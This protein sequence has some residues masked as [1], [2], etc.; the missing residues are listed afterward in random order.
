[1][2]VADGLVKFHSWSTTEGC[3]LMRDVLHKWIFRFNWSHLRQ[4]RGDIYR[5]CDKDGDHKHCLNTALTLRQRGRVF[6]WKKVL[7]NLMGACECLENIKSMFF[8]NTHE[9][10]MYTGS[11]EFALSRKCINPLS[12][13]NPVENSWSLPLELWSQHITSLSSL[14]LSNV[15]NKNEWITHVIFTFVWTLERVNDRWMNSIDFCTWRPFPR[16]RCFNV[17]KK[18]SSHQSTGSE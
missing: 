2:G 13:K 12:V 6:S 3:S 7:W 5:C 11:R 4:F 14:L 18:D 15:Q 16:G 9:N 1:M 10:K 8:L 17:A